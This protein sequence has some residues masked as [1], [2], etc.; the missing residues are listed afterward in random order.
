MCGRKLAPL[1]NTLPQ[2][3]IFH[4]Q[5]PRHV[6]QPR[7]DD[8]IMFRRPGRQE[9]SQDRRD[10]PLELDRHLERL[11]GTFVRH[12]VRE[13]LGEHAHAD[14]QIVRPVAC[15]SETGY[16]DRALDAPRDD[17]RCTKDRSHPVLLPSRL[18]DVR[19]RGNVAHLRYHNGAPGP[20]ALDR[21]RK[22]LG[23]PL[24]RHRC[25][26]AF[27]DPGVAQLNRIACQ[28]DDLCA[29]DVQQ[30]RDLLQCVGDRA[31]DL[32]SRQVDEACR[33][34]RQQ[35]FE[36]K[37][38]ARNYTRGIRPT[39][40]RRHRSR[41]GRPWIARPSRHSIPVL[42]NPQ[43]PSLRHVEAGGRNRSRSK[44]GSRERF[45]PWRATLLEREYFSFVTLT[46]V[47]TLQA[48]MRGTRTRRTARG[49]QHVAS[50]GC[51]QFPAFY[52]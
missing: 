10:V 44:R 19:L 24:R 47:D 21:P 22:E 31:V 5:H 48:R 12:G 29:I 42:A 4:P 27:N 49:A 36:R 35:P 39:S 32:G 23:D 8:A 46:T 37:C 25:K 7:L 2:R 50:C 26:S 33:Q 6:A 41:H 17:H 40:G 13:Y 1:S 18:V 28:A 16:D 43:W 52:H 30:Q 3:G 51:G 9:R 38:F 20:N 11:P 45:P 15:V 34:F 14:D